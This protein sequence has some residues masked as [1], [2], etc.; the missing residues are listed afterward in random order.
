[1]LK[2]ILSKYFTK[3]IYPTYPGDWYKRKGYNGFSPQELFADFI[4]KQKITGSIYHKEFQS[5]KFTRRFI[6]SGNH[7]IDSVE[8]KPYT[9][10]SK[11]Q[12][13]NGLY[14]LCF[15]GKGEYYE[16][17]FRD[18][19]LFAKNTGATIVAFNPKGF[20]TSTGKT[21]CLSDIA[22]DGI[23]IIDHLLTRSIHPA[24]IILYGN[25]LGAVVQELVCRHFKHSRSINFRQINSNSF[26]TLTAVIMANSKIAFLEKI[27][28]YLMKYAGWEIDYPEDFYKTGIYRCYLTRKGDKIIKPNISF[29][30]KVNMSIDLANA[31]V[32]YQETLKWLNERSELIPIISTN[33]DP[34]EL[35]LNNLCLETKD[36]EGTNLTVW[37][38]INKYLEASNRFIFVK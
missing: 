31:P 12:P 8:I 21:K 19:A 22:Q 38:F 27:V 26:S 32:G 36:K 3:L 13:G 34:H 11:N 30:N 25:S 1:M 28:S 2:V 7:K 5:L 20:H 23:A 37:D 18:M 4:Q 24:Q 10:I 6:I 15:F 35:S 29:G 17:R 33:K 9:K 14:I 16:S